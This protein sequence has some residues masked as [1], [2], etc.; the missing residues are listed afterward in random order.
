MELGNL[1]GSIHLE[2]AKRRPSRAGATRIASMPALLRQ[3]QA[4]KMRHL[5]K[6]GDDIR[7]YTQGQFAQL[8][9]NVTDVFDRCVV[10]VRLLHRSCK[11]T[12]PS[13][14]DRPC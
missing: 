5:Q 8:V 11:L 2:T 6:A 9:A 4:F 14:I 7:V 1:T 3:I 13:H 10:P 12:G